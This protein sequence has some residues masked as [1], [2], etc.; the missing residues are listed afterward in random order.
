MSYSTID[1]SIGFGLANFLFTDS[2]E[3]SDVTYSY[4]SYLTKK[5]SVLIARYKKDDTEARYYLT[6]G[7]YDTIWAGRAGYTYVLP[8]Q[9][10]YPKA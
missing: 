1:S 3:T 6:R 5:G 4:V 8:T 10:N 9:L 2:D 7:D